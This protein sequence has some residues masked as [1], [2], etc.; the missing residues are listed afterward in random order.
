MTQGVAKA[1]GLQGDYPA[2]VDPRYSIGVQAIDM[3]LPEYW[4]LRNGRRSCYYASSPAVA[5]KFSF[6]WLGIASPD[7]GPMI[8][9]ERIRVIGG[10]AMDV[11]VGLATAVPAGAVSG[12]GQGFVMDD[13]AWTG[14]AAG[15]GLGL[16]Q[17]GNANAAAYVADETLRASLTPGQDYPGPWILTGRLGLYILA[18]TANTALNVTFYTR[19]RIAP[20]VE[21]FA[22]ASG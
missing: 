18:Q 4:F 2:A 10:A 7:L 15:P 9:V 20:R 19:E 16:M 6:L 8:V 14:S 11:R 13:R 1:I 17:I 5:A 22:P 3:E 21:L 12:Q